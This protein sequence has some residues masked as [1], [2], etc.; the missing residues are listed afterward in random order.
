MNLL[1]ILG[2]IGLVVVG[3]AI[4]LFNNKNES[5][6]KTESES[7]KSTDDLIAE[8]Y[9]KF[10]DTD[11]N[12]YNV[13]GCVVPEELLQKRNRNYDE[14]PNWVKKGKICADAGANLSRAFFDVI[15]M[16]YDYY[17]QYMNCTEPEGYY[18]GGY[19]YNRPQRNEYYSGGHRIINHGYNQI[20]I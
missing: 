6:T 17:G 8:K 19:S 18:N 1:K 10:S 4:L 14:T 11:E 13:K 12:P 5:N 3:G 16:G 9:E 2:G 15:T 7:E 20:I